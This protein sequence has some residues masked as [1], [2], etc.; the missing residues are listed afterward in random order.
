LQLTDEPIARMRVTPAGR[1]LLRLLGDP[2]AE[3]SR[4]PGRGGSSTA[5]SVATRS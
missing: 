4:R 3:K 2:C 5:R 1:Q